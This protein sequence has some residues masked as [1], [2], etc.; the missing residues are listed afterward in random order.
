MDTSWCQVRNC[1]L[2]CFN[3]YVK[4]GNDGK[5]QAEV[6]DYNPDANKWTKVGQLAKARHAHGIS[7]VPN[8]TADYCG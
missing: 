2:T 3:V 1:D 6:L 4:G 8:E 5:L 7:L